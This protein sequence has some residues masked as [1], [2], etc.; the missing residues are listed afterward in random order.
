MKPGERTFSLYVAS[1]VKCAGK[2]AL[3]AYYGKK[4]MKL[5]TGPLTVELPVQD[6]KLTGSVS[7]A[8]R[9]TATDYTSASARLIKGDLQRADPAATCSAIPS[10]LQLRRA[11]RDVAP[12]TTPGKAVAGAAYFG[13]MSGDSQLTPLLLHISAKGTAVSNRLAELY[14]DC[15]AKKPY[16]NFIVNDFA[17]FPIDTNGRFEFHETWSTT[18]AKL[19]LTPNDKIEITTLTKG[20]FAGKHGVGLVRFDAK[21]IDPATGKVIDTCTSQDQPFDLST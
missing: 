18:G 21:I 9:F 16:E 1:G 12:I 5:G 11:R 17:Q 19:G 15:V 3:L 8:L 2:T 7:V 20:A 10:A 13:A 14:L 4:D 6:P